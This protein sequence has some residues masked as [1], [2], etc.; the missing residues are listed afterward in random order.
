[1]QWITPSYAEVRFGFEITMYIAN[2]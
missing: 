2:R 1:M